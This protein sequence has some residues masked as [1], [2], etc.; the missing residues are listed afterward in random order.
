MRINKVSWIIT[1]IV[2]PTLT[3]ANEIEVKKASAE[4]AY[5]QLTDQYW[6]IWITDPLGRSPRQVTQDKIDNTRISWYPDR[7]SLL[8]NRS[9]GR[10]VRVDVQNGNVQPLTLP[11]EGMFDAQLDPSGQWIAFS[12][13][14]SRPDT[15]NLWKVRLDGAELTKLTHQPGLQ[16]APSWGMQ[17]QHI[18]YIGLKLN[19]RNQLWSLDVTTGTQKQ[20][21]VGKISNHFDPV[22]N[23]HG[24]IAYS[25]DQQ[26]H[27]DLWMIEAKTQKTRALTQAQGFEGEPTWAPSGDELAYI[28]V[29][30]NKRQLKVIDKQ[31]SN[32]RVVVEGKVRG[33]AWWR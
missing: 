8:A 27:Y 12:V 21:T 4:I 26:G 22:Y 5:L 18:T 1:F 24:D 10:L 16:L 3:W 30:Q 33:P 28:A 29:N 13:P 31:G 32:S 11:M 6:Q 9:D 15:N 7:Q 2:L 17:S 19:A 23:I 14:S 25:K 20:L